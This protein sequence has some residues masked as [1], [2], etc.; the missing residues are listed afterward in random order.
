MRINISDTSL[1]FEVY[2]NKVNWQGE[3]THEK[4]TLIFLHGGAGFLNQAPYLTFWS[5]FA[6]VAQVIFLDQRG[7]DCD[8]R[9]RRLY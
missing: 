9:H 5:R 3:N 6:D 7:S 4:P 1:F 8:D 2:G